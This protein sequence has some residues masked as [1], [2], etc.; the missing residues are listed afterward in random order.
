MK[1]QAGRKSIDILVK[2]QSDLP[3]INVDFRR[4]EQ[5]LVNLVHNAIKYSPEGADLELE[6]V[7]DRDLL[8]LSVT[9]QGPGIPRDQAERIFERFF[10]TDRA[11]SSGGTGLGLSIARHLVEAHGG[12][13]WV[14]TIEGE[15]SRF[16][17]S[18]PWAAIRS[19]DQ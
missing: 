16:T 2:A 10:K 15:G 11:R 6:A 18:I 17:F 8:L 4:I 12:K 13:I 3:E 7:R 19:P 5:V 14:E 9:D 1:A